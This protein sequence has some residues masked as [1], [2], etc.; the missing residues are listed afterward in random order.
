MNRR[1][2]VTITANNAPGVGETT[3]LEG[4]DSAV[5]GL[6]LPADYTSGSTG[7]SK[8]MA[9]AGGAFVTAFLM[10]FMLTFKERDNPDKQNETVDGTALLIQFFLTTIFLPV[11]DL[12]ISI[13]FSYLYYYQANNLKRKSKKK[14]LKEQKPSW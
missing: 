3:I 14:V 7:R 4:I 2:Q 10:A 12:L 1:R 9:R 11:K 8:E 5:K 6:G 13:S